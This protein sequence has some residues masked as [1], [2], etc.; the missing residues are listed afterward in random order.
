MYIGKLGGDR[1]IPAPSDRWPDLRT[2]CGNR[3]PTRR[4]CFFRNELRKVNEI[5]SVS[6]Y[7]ASSS[8]IFCCCVGGCWS[9]TLWFTLFALLALHAIAEQSVAI[10]VLHVAQKAAAVR[11]VDGLAFLQVIRRR[12]LVMRCWLNF[13]CCWLKWWFA[14]WVLFSGCCFCLN[15]ELDCSSLM[16]FSRTTPEAGSAGVTAA[17]CG[18][19]LS[20]ADWSSFISWYRLGPKNLRKKC[21]CRI[22]LI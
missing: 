19:R 14:G 16:N 21:Q 17:L 12:L 4:W 8:W 18:G 3:S 9:G 13:C 10:H 1:T 2:D 20:G 5:L 11:L 6:L 15:I 22:T 7:C